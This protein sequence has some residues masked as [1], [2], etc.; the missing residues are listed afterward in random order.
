VALWEFHLKLSQF[1]RIKVNAVFTQITVN[2]T[3]GTKYYKL[4]I[5]TSIFLV[6]SEKLGKIFL[7]FVVTK[8]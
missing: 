8:I 7:I 2:S 4:L 1:F 6:V 3:V 5:I